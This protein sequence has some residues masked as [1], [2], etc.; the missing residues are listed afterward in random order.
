MKYSIVI[1]CFNRSKFIG[2][3]I[4]SAINQKGIERGT[5]EVIVVDD[6]SKDNSVSILRDYENIIRVI[7]NKKNMGLPYSRNK[8]IKNSKGKYILML[9]SDD[10]ISEYT[11][12]ILG[13]FL[14]HNPDWDA[15]SCD[16]YL[17]NLKG[18]ELKREYFSNRPIACGILYRRQS[19]FSVGLYNEKFRML[20]DI[21]FRKK[22]LLNY[23]IG[24][25]E[26]PLYRYTMHKENMTKNKLILN[27]YKKKLQNLNKL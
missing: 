14:D 7:L 19:I 5:H 15:A 22:Y 9:D 11:L 10:Y 20:E 21:E 1:T 27:K 2:R 23:N 24:N 6:C 13:N 12:N 17:V 4:R 8:G 26:L 16:Y 3:A 18:M 25:V